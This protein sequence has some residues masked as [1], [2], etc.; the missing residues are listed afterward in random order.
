MKNICVCKHIKEAHKQLESNVYC[1]AYK[2]T[3]G[4]EFCGCKE[5]IPR[6]NN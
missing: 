6:D 2:Y 4:E 5:F 3:V 1:L